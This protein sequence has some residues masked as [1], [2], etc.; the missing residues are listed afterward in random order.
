M[1]VLYKKIYY[2]TVDIYLCFYIK[3][4]NDTVNDDD[5]NSER[6]VKNLS[7]AILQ[8]QQAVELKFMNRPL[9]G[10]CLK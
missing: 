8:I 1:Y 6:V 4:D 3:I 2:L 7:C 10:K 9:V 5:T